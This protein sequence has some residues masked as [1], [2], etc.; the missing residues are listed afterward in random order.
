M[1]ILYFHQHFGTPSGS[2]G[3]RSYEIARRLV[4]T[5]HTVTLVCGSI[6]GNGI[7][8][9]K[10]YSKGY[11][12]DLVEG[13]D[14]IELDLRYANEDN[15]GKR[16]LTFL[17]YAVRSIYI[18]LSEPY[19]IVFAT[20]TPLTA[21]VP[22]IAARWLRRK[23]FVFEVRDLWPEVPRAMGVIKNPVILGLMSGLEW[24]SYHSANRLIGL[25]PGMV[26]GIVKRGIPRNRVTLIPNGCDLNIFQNSAEP[27]RPANVDPSDFMAIYTGTHGMANGLDALIPIAQE[28]QSRGMTDI[29]LVLVGEGKLKAK[30]QTAIK[31]HQLDEIVIF[32]PPTRKYDL[33]G[34]MQSA[35][36]GIMMFADI[37]AF[38][39]GTSPNKFFDYISAGLPVLVTYPGWM[40]ELIEE[41]NCGFAVCPNDAAAFVDALEQAK[42][43]PAALIAM[44]D[45]ALSLASSEFDR[46]QLAKQ[47]IEWVTTVA[48]N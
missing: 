26:D 27:W 42:N 43:E 31:T 20:T 13:I 24:V 3:T 44:G 12:R 8:I 4:D 14:V 48:K 34:L 10:P 38:Y 7:G 5:G 32:H 36:L 37:P 9:E 35:N 33:A 15:F 11:R 28:I 29:R 22:G 41:N 46:N 23:P 17:K 39:Y 6:A 47:W 21:S 45:N 19:D 40:K 1:H 18:A 25:S 30:L 16:T 2:V